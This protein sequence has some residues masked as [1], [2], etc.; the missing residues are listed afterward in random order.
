MRLASL[1]S[2]S[3][4]IDAFAPRGG[5]TIPEMFPMQPEA[6][7]QHRDLCVTAQMYLEK[8]PN[9]APTSQV[10]HHLS[11]CSVWTEVCN[12]D[13]DGWSQQEE[14]ICGSRG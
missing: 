6:A 13:D 14:D 8:S 3:A 12:Q 7:A 9:S 11:H 10:A 2:I 4:S 5:S 1:R